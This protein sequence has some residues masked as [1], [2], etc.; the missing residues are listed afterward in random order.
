ME[1]YGLIVL[2]GIVFIGIVI[3]EI[4]Y[5]ID[6]KRE[7][8]KS[9]TVYVYKKFKYIASEFKISKRHGN[10]KDYPLLE[11]DLESYSMLL[12]E[13]AIDFINISGLKRQILIL[14]E[15]EQKHKDELQKEFERSIAKNNPIKE[16]YKEKENIKNAVLNSRKK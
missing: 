4:I 6:E 2:C 3:M 13:V 8:K 9:F 11:K 7:S 1:D 10:F 16:I 14:D 12:E 15:W 5:K